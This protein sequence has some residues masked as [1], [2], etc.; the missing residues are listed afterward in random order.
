MVAEMGPCAFSDRY[1]RA[2]LIER[3]GHEAPTAIRAAFAATVA[4]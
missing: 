1:N 4:A 2:W 3:H